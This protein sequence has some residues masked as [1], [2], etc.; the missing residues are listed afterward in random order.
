MTHDAIY[1]RTLALR[2]SGSRAD[3][4]DDM[5]AG[6]I[7]SLP[8][9]VKD[10]Q[11]FFSEK[12]TEAFTQTVHRLHGLACYC[13]VPGLQQAVAALERESKKIDSTSVP[14]KISAFINEAE[15]LLEHI[16]SRNI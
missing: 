16:A 5:L 14:E 6:L 7:E 12:N 13:G 9:T 10:I 15:K 4:A 8:Q 3:L 2:L 1:D 11:S